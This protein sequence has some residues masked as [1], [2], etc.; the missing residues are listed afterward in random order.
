MTR[1]LVRWVAVALLLFGLGWLP[2]MS[3]GA[4]TAP[5]S[6][7]GRALSASAPAAPLAS[8]ASRVSGWSVAPGA[9]RVGGQLSARVVVSPAGARVVSVQYRRLGTLRFVTASRVLSSSS[10]VAFVWLR[11]PAAGRWQFRVVVSASGRAAAVASAVRLVVASGRAAVTRLAGFDATTAQVTVGGAATDDVSLLP[12]SVR[13]VWVQARRGS[14]AFA[15]VGTVR[16]SSSGA[17]RVAYRPGSVGTWVYR[18]VA[19][20]T[21]TATG[22]ASPS[23]VITAVAVT[24]PGPTPTPTPTP[25]PVPVPPSGPTAK[26]TV[27]TSG[28]EASKL[29]VEGLVS[30]DARA[31]QAA[32]GQTLTGATIDFGD[33]TAVKDL[34]GN[35]AKWR[36]EHAYATAGTKTATLTVTSSDGK[37]AT[38]TTSV[39]V[40][41]TPTVTIVQ[42]GGPAVAG[43]QVTFAVTATTPAGSAFTDYDV[44]YDNGAT[45]AFGDGTPPA[46]LTHTF[47][48]PG[49]YTVILDG[50]NDADGF[51]RSTITVTVQ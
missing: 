11:P 27:D 17:V 51:S 23:R 49:T 16:T 34:G 42:T 37:S 33:G 1:S 31:S 46:T 19:P 45:V 12:R 36:A 25:T 29:T 15:T 44:T 26:L 48:A 2:V 5:A 20:A 6:A 50:Y 3:S 32:A 30:F 22:V 41:S 18:L 24:S 38:V 39:P 35:A 9:V 40:F 47:A 14:G 8:V 7:G 43:Q 4:S 10:G 28:L 13:S 21:A